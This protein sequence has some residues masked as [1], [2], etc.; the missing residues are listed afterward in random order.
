ME[1][2]LLRWFG[3]F[4]AVFCIGR[5]VQGDMMVGNAGFDDTPLAPGGYTYS[6]G[7]W[8]TINEGGGP[9]AWISNGYYAN[10]S[11]P[12][13]AAMYTTSDDVW[14]ELTGTFVA[15]VTYTFSMDIGT[16]SS[17]QSDPF[18]WRLF[19]F[20]ATDGDRTTPVAE[21]TG[22]FSASATGGDP[23]NIGGAAVQYTATAADEG[24]LIGIGLGGPAT[25]Y[26]TLY[27]NALVI[28][29]PSSIVLLL[30]GGVG[31]LAV[32]RHIGA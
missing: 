28:P 19:L 11:A 5:S 13:S 22:T 10:E 12:N 21:A 20:N 14:Q 18:S 29:E 4:L 17:T 27:D 1:C 32:R 3:V 24:D 8:Q 30:L 7:A 6:L 26:Y 31:V 15:G 16:R 23:W 2:K 9:P 25:S